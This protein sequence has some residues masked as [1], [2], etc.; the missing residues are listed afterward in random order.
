[1]LSFVSQML[2]QGAEQ[3]YQAPV[4]ARDL[5][6]RLHRPVRF[7][8]AILQATLR[9]SLRTRRIELDL[10]TARMHVEQQ[11]QY[12]GGGPLNSKDTAQPLQ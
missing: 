7:S 1:M 10:A 6:Q 11:G 2:W 5:P 9:G 12:L 8:P 4:P 3:K